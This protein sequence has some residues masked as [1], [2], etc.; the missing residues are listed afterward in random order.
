M[1]DSAQPYPE[2]AA[3]ALD[4]TPYS[5][6]DVPA[7]KAKY[8]PTLIVLCR[9]GA[10]LRVTVAPV[11]IIKFGVLGRCVKPVPATTLAAEG[12]GDFVGRDH[13]LVCTPPLSGAQTDILIDMAVS[14][15]QY[16]AAHLR[17]VMVLDRSLA[18]DTEAGA[19]A[20]ESIVIDA[21]RRLDL[22]TRNFQAADR[23]VA[24]PTGYWDVYDSGAA[25]TINDD[26]LATMIRAYAARSLRVRYP[27]P[28]ADPA[29]TEA[30]RDIGL[31]LKRYAATEKLAD[32]LMYA[33]YCSPA[34]ARVMFT[35]PYREFLSKVKV[36]QSVMPIDLL[37]GEELSDTALRLRGAR[38]AEHE[39]EPDETAEGL[40]A[41]LQAVRRTDDL[42]VASDVVIGSDIAACAAVQIALDEYGLLMSAG[43]KNRDAIAEAL[44]RLEEQGIF[45]RRYSRTTERYVE[46][47]TDPEMAL[48]HLLLRNA[49]AN[50]GRA[51]E[52]PAPHRTAPSPVPGAAPWVFDMDQILAFKAPN[53]PLSAEDAFARLDYYVGG[54]LG[55]LDLR[56]T[57]LTG[58]AIAAALI[59]V[60]RAKYQLQMYALASGVVRL[61]RE[62]TGAKGPI[63]DRVKYL[64]WLDASP[65]G[66]AAHY[67]AYV[68]SLYPAK[69]TVPADDAALALYREYASGSHA[70]SVGKLE[71]EVIGDAEKPQMRISLSL[72][73]KT[74]AVL[75]IR[76]G[77]DVDMA[78]DVATDA[79][80]DDVAR[81]HF[82]V[83]RGRH[84]DATLH[85]V[86][87]PNG[88][89]SW[90][91]RGDTIGFRHVEMYRAT[92]D[93][94]VTHHVGMVSGA[95]TARFH[96]KP[97]FVVSARLIYAMVHLHTP[98]YYYFASRKCLPQEIVL[99][100]TARGFGLQSFPV[101]IVCAID[102]M[103][104]RG[105]RWLGT[106][107]P[108]HFPAYHGTGNFSAVSLPTERGIKKRI[109]AFGW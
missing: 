63:R 9:E 83:I 72:S 31:I 54:Y 42:H 68:D 57:L 64:A 25:V 37:L 26:K 41:R 107:S 15:S 27:L 3:V 74:P 60:E 108:L 59:R 62:E 88:T 103:I 21:V 90:A 38:E 49:A 76:P 85:R 77:A 96:D 7:L 101:G 12:L 44:Y 105:S 84:P 91:V 87:R 81:G 93:H 24:M 23:S 2:W 73:G 94:V 67:R 92:F 16:F 40:L 39:P 10:D 47:T 97:T 28:V 71:Y 79:E 53:G 82:E 75:D 99:K 56:R 89:Y 61:Y 35:S 69:Y 78:I 102:S 70:A 1:S 58:G 34:F 66:R 43:R 18:L 45:P 4:D 51:S 6:A 8:G 98:N 32:S 52:T 106:G 36:G 29:E 55:D 80:F 17:R 19:R 100:Y 95:Y 46:W 5:E 30:A 14:E 20:V 50:R 86:D 48:P 22:E 109:A 11:E 33:L 104:Q 65:A 13:W